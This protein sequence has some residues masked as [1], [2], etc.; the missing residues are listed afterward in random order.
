MRERMNEIVNLLGKIVWLLKE[1]NYPDEALWYEE[2]ISKLKNN[3]V[4]IEKETLL[5]IYSSL[6]GMGSFY[7]IPLVPS[8][9]SKISE[10][11][12]RKEQWELV[13]KLGDQ[14]N[15]QIENA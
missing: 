4:G 11:E 10:V 7:D 8:K 12:L 6:A 15:Y 3:K 2:K 14:I 5:E 1:Y 9:D 13:E